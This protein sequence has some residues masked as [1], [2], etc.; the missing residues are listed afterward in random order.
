MARATCY[1]QDCPVCGRPVQ[2]R[3]EYLGKSVTCQHCSGRFQASD[4]EN[5]I[6]SDQRT[7]AKLMARVAELLERSEPG[8][9]SQ[10]PVS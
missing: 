10:W 9:L 5:P 8:Q 7:N 4:P 3:I 1:V 2:V 6:R